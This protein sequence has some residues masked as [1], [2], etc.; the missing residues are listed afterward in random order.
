MTIFT[1]VSIEASRNVDVF[2]SNDGDSLTLQDCLGNNCGESTQKVT[3]TI[4][5]N[6]LKKSTKTSRDEKT[7][8]NES[9]LPSSRLKDVDAEW[10]RRVG[11]TEKPT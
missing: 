6:W 5:D 11:A 9:R 10:F 1:F 4:N 2:T 3:T 7:S 8:R